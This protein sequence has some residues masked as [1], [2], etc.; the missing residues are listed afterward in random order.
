[1]SDEKA[2]LSKED[3]RPF[4]DKQRAVTANKTCFDCGARNPTWSSATFGVFIC[5]DCS[6][7]HRNLGVHVSFVQ[8]TNMDNWSIGHL[9]NIRVGGNQAAREFFTK[10]GGSRY[11]TKSASASEKYSSRVAQLYLEELKER[12]ERDA[13]K[14]PNEHVLDDV[15]NS[16]SPGASSASSSKKDEDFFSSWDKPMVK[17]PTPPL[18][19]S[20]TPVSSSAGTSRSG[21]PLGTTTTT[22]T[23]TTRIA[24]KASS[25]SASGS[26]RNILGSKRAPKLSAKK[27]ASEEIDFEKA[28]REAREE[29]ERIAKLGYNPNEEAAK[30][31]PAQTEAA[32]KKSYTEPAALADLRP[33]PTV[34][35]PSSTTTAPKPQSVRLGFGQTA[36]PPSQKSATP[37]PRAYTPAAPTDPAITGKYG[38]Q[39]AISS[40]EFFGRNNFDP[41]AQAEARTRLKQFE[42]ASSISSSSYFGR[43]E[44]EEARG[45]GDGEFD[46]EQLTNN[47]ADKLRG[48]ANEDMGAVK[49]ALEQGAAKAAD[50]VRN[51]MR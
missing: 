16:P 17:K 36:A 12:A 37:T 32:A 51:F 35:K 7:V 24:G 43:D 21:T 41:A 20:S 19:R 14:H 27:V 48:L 40:D 47:L 22:T 6:A 30:Q 23:T 31:S 29:Q 8:S 11:L 44:E 38:K 34:L 33:E 9:R 13:I 39:K 10:N 49:D 50:Y 15:E 2:S 1:M 45:H 42:G 25:S 26:R 46:M 28:E 5:L 18:S 3:I 4:F